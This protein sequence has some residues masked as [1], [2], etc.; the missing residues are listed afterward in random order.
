MVVNA[1]QKMMSAT[2]EP[3]G[4]WGGGFGVTTALMWSATV[5]VADGLWVR[6]PK[7]SPLPSSKAVGASRQTVAGATLAMA[8]P[9]ICLKDTKCAHCGSFHFFLRNHS[10][11]DKAVPSR[12]APNLD[13]RGF[14]ASSV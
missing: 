5:Y 9:G 13:P 4:G 7:Q 10:V 11:L 3:G 1:F 6:V 8:L 12:R 2:E 14:L